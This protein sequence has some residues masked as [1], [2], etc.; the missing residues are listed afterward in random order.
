MAK[1]MKGD[2]VSNVAEQTGLGKKQ[3]NAAVDAV[4]ATIQ[5]ALSNGDSVALIGFG[6][7]EVRTRAARK[8]R[9]LATGE[10]MDIPEKNV[11]AFKAGKKLRDAVA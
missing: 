7:F 11:P 8:G 1:L 2:I 10:E 9:N 4:V 3:A 6:T 5:G